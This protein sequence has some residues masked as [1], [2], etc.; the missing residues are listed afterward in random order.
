MEEDLH[1][2]FDVALCDRRKVLHHVQRCRSIGVDC[3]GQS[4][5]KGRY[6]IEPT[7]LAEGWAMKR[8]WP[9]LFVLALVGCAAGP[10]IDARYRSMSQDSRVKKKQEEYESQ[11]PNVLWF[12]E[13]LAKHGYAVP[14]S[15]ELDKATVQ[16]LIVFQMKYRSSRY[17]G[18]P[19]AETAALLGAD[20][21]PDE[22]EGDPGGDP[23]SPQNTKLRRRLCS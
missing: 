12:Q 1:G 10:H 18:T 19:D 17:D 7:V 20:L 9:I 21:A 2:V 23:R 4:L 6:G 8:I 14:L 15:G 16:V 11:L 22:R 13:K 5:G 3:L